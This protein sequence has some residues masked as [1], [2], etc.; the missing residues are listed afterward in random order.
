MGTYLAAGFGSDMSFDG[1]NFS[2]AFVDA[3]GIHR[4]KLLRPSDLSVVDDPDGFLVTATAQGRVVV[5]GAG[6]GRSIWAFA[7]AQATADP[8]VYVRFV[9]GLDP[10]APDAGADGGLDAAPDGPDAEPDAEPDVQAMGDAPDT[11]VPADAGAPD[12]AD[13]LTSDGAGADSRD[14]A[15]PAPDDG[16][17]CGCDLGGHRR[18]ASGA[19]LL[20]VLL[21][22]AIR[23]RGKFT[24]SST[25]RAP[26]T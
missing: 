24:R 6:G 12:V 25:S 10:P 15:G 5:A 7:S 20:L 4:G 9:G 11:M 18:P 19:G 3:A 14:A 22:L 13:A 17:S 26:W 21:A 2:Y 1:L 23:S 16:G 8:R